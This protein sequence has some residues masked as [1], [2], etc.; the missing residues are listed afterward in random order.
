MF[1]EFLRKLRQ[2]AFAG[3]EQITEIVERL[4]DFAETAGLLPMLKNLFS[5]IKLSVGSSFVY[6][7][8]ET[9]EIIEQIVP[10]L[11]EKVKEG[12]MAAQDRLCVHIKDAIGLVVLCYRYTLVEIY[13]DYENKET[14]LQKFNSQIDMVLKG[15]IATLNGKID[16]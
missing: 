6:I 10:L 5:E 7:A 8:K 9:T 15:F 12:A 4:T 14:I 16:L 1:K 13:N 3:V 2:D 11:L